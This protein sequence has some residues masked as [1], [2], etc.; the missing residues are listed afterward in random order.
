MAGVAALPPETSYDLILAADVLVYLGAL[1]PLFAEV[2]SR[3]TTNGLFAFTVQAQ[4][5]AGF[6]LG[7]DMRFAHSATYIET[8]ATAAGLGL[9]SLQPVSTRQDAGRPV[10]G[11]VVLLSA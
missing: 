2:K 8:A 11:H 10:P 1:E 5:A 6:A 9:E 3:L 7:E 4:D